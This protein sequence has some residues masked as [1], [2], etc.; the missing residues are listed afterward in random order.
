MASAVEH[1]RKGEQLLAAA[2]IPLEAAVD[3]NLS[4]E[5]R[6]EASAMA[7]AAAATAQAHFTAALAA[8]TALTG[9]MGSYSDDPEIQAWVEAAG[10]KSDG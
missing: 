1:Y 6:R 5:E 10:V 2:E 7:H 3:T 8:T 4:L 9:P